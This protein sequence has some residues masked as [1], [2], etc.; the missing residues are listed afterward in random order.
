MAYDELTLA[1]NDN[2]GMT[3]QWSTFENEDSIKVIEANQYYVSKTN[4]HQCTGKDTIDVYP[5][6]RPVS[7][8]MPNIFTPNG[9]GINDYF[10][11]IEVPHEELEYLIANITKIT[12]SIHNRWGQIVYVSNDILPNW[13]GIHLNKGNECPAGTYYWILQYEDTS[14]E[15]YSKNGFVQLTR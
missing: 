14:G 8:T 7:L 12:F 6:C 5:Y 15:N 9:D 11:P 4:I 13:N 3:I 2:E 10:I 1:I